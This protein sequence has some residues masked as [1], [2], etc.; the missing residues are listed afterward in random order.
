MTTFLWVIV[1]YVCL[2]VFVVGMFVAGLLLRSR[3]ALPP[4]RRVPTRRW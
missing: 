1:P 3:S 2:A 4:V